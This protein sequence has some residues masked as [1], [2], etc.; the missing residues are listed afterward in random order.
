MKTIP[1]LIIL[2]TAPFLSRAQPYIDLVNTRIVHSPSSYDKAPS[3][4]YPIQYFNLS[5]NL[6]IRLKKP[7]SIVILSPFIDRWILP[8]TS[9]DKELRLTS[10]AFPVTAILPAG[11]DWKLA[12]TLILRINDSMP[13]SHGQVQVGGAFL[14]EKKFSENFQLRVGVYL[15]SEL[16][17]L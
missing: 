14:G 17:G 16:F 12:T 6:P 3:G 10:L 9:S 1:A 8:S 4:S 13:A 15:N 2:L 11:N 7:G 5:T